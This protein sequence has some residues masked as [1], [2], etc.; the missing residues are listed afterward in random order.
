MT[1]TTQGN[2]ILGKFCGVIYDE[3]YNDRYR[4][5][6][7]WNWLHESWEK[8]RAID[9]PSPDVAYLFYGYRSTIESAMVHGTILEAFT[10]LVEAVEWWNGLNEKEVGNGTTTE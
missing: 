3:K 2:I 1:V 10:A 6:S 9:L 8:F 4:Y 5:H 7:D